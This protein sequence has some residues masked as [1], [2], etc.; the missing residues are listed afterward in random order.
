MYQQVWGEGVFDAYNGLTDWTNQD[1]G[2]SGGEGK[3]QCGF[4]VIATSAWEM[5][6]TW[7]P[8]ELVYLI[9]VARLSFHELWGRR[10]HNLLGHFCGGSPLSLRPCPGFSETGCISEWGVEILAFCPKR[11]PDAFWFGWS[12]GGVQ[13][14]FIPGMGLRAPRCFSLPEELRKKDGHSKSLCCI[15]MKTLVTKFV[16]CT[17]YG[18]VNTLVG[19]D[20]RWT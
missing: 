16:K 4:C 18:K 10:P 1:L 19:L 13:W 9:L 6:G 20:D 2:R 11:A 12:V 8:L 17:E 15:N 7:V 14:G 3:E 5:D